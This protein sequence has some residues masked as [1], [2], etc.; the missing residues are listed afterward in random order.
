MKKNALNSIGR[1]THM[2][3]IKEFEKAIHQTFT[4]EW[5]KTPWELYAKDCF[6]LET[7]CK[8]RIQ[9]SSGET[10]MEATIMLQAHYHQ[11]TKSI[12]REN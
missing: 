5:S 10:R 9:K 8:E 12:G 11:F 7:E 2:R 1:F 3:R 6:K 4:E